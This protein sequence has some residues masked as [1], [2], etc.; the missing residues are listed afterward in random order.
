MKILPVEQM[1][2]MSLQGLVLE[3]EAVTEEMVSECPGR[4]VIRRLWDMVWALVSIVGKEGRDPG[5][6]A[7]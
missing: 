7:V 1:V 3:Q 2:L 4:G 6:G 5:A